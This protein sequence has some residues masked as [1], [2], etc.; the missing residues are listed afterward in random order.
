M[1]SISEI[2]FKR[3]IQKFTRMNA[4]KRMLLERNAEEGKPEQERQVT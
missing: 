2:L 4:F 1:N 3:L